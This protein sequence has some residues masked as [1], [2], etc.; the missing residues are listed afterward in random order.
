MDNNA[1][2]DKPVL[3][4]AL[5]HGLD[6]ILPYISR[7]LAAYEVTLCHDAPADIEI[8]PEAPATPSAPTVLVCPA[9]V[10][11]G[12]TGLPME[13]A[14]SVAS[15]RF[16]HIKGNTARLSVVHA[17]DVARAAALALGSE[18]VWTVTDGDDPTFDALA[19]ALARRINDKRILTVKPLAAFFLMS[20]ALRRTVTT[21][22][23]ADG[24]EFAA[25]FSFK[26]TPV[27]EYLTTHVY[28]D[29]SL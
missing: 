13:L 17:S 4:V 2:V 5:G 10:G 7:E 6:F 12:M 11:T 16:F 1:S 15:G 9:V 14:R 28:D 27:T 20:P 22:R 23:L 26:A 24:S 25:R 19:D 8:A 21:D 18:G 29:E 3:R